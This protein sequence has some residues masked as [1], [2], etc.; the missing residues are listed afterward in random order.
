[1]STRPDY[2]PETYHDFTKPDADAAQRAALADVRQRFGKEYD[3][4]IGGKRVKGDAGTFTSLNPA[5]LSE[6]IGT[7]Q[8]AS[9]DQARQALAAAWNA[10]ETWR[11]VPAQK[12]A[13]IIFK[14]A[15][16]ARRRRMEINAWMISEAGKNFLEADADTC[17]GIDFLE[18]YAHEALRYDK[19][20]KVLDAWGDRALAG[21]D[22]EPYTAADVEAAR[23]EPLTNVQV[24]ERRVALTVP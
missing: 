16:I 7:F 10:F 8:M 14:A 13:D 2:K 11:Y 3:L 15:D 9:A 21:D 24:H 19:G 23:G 18:Y 5:N 4:F 6:T 20:M 1:M 17:E 12:R 22:H